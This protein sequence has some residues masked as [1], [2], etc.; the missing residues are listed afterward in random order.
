LGKQIAALL[1]T[2]T[3]LTGVANGNVRPEL[4]TIA[5]LEGVAKVFVTSWASG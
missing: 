4:K 2:E 5:V 1:D 3:L